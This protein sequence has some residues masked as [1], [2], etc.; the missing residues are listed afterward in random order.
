MFENF[1]NTASL[2][3]NEIV[4]DAK[5]KHIKRDIYKYD[6]KLNYMSVVPTLLNL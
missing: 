2:N 3:S 4:R 6:F 1:K 5:L